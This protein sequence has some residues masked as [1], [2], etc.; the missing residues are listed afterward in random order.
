MAKGGAQAALPNNTWSTTPADRLLAAPFGMPGG[1]P[2]QPQAVAQVAQGGGG[3]PKFNTDREDDIRKQ[4]S[5][6]TNPEAPQLDPVPKAPI[7]QESDPFGG[8][9]P[10]V[11]LLGGLAAGK[12]RTPA[13]TMLNSFA[14]FNKARAAGDSERAKAAHEAW[15]DSAQQVVDT[16][17]D[18]LATYKEVLESN[19]GDKRALEAELT[20]L[21][22]EDKLYAAMHKDDGSSIYEKVSDWHDATQ[23]ATDK[24]DQHLQEANKPLEPGQYDDKALVGLKPDYAALVK[25]V[26][27]NQ[28]PVSALGRTKDRALLEGK[29]LEYNKDWNAAGYD[30]D[31]ARDMSLRKGPDHLAIE[32]VNRAINHAGTLYAAAHLIDNKE[33]QKVNEL[34]N[35]W[36]AHV[37]EPKIEAYRT[38]AIALADE[39]AKAFAGTGSGAEAEKERWLARLGDVKSPEQFDSILG[40][41]A[42]LLHGQMAAIADTNA[43]NGGK[44]Q[45]DDLVLGDAKGAWSKLK[46]LGPLGDKSGGAP[47]PPK[48]GE[49]VDG[50]KFKGGA[51]GDQNNWEKQ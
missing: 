48:V 19:K 45:P 25:G 34:K 10:I 23:K 18:R 7:A 17:K 46:G 21:I 51:A 29:V 4:L 28:L 38:A 26:A 49:I 33:Y 16:N 30:L 35:N 13:T 47:P 44:L 6:N 2:G 41:A 36:N 12:T 15:K 1:V 37:G 8:M 31:K 39:L 22:S 24:L 11:M 42:N 3:V 50:Y 43:F 14:E 32:S 40:T 9:A 27:T 20:S 5:Q